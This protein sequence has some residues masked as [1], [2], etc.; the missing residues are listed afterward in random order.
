MI[1]CG[2]A[3]DRKRI[4]VAGVA[5]L[6]WDLA[7]RTEGVGPL[8]WRRME[9]VF[10]ALTCPVQASFRTE[11]M[12]CFHGMEGNGFFDRR[13]LRPF[14][15]EQSA[16]LIYGRRIWHGA[17]ERGGRVGMMFWQQSLGE[18]VDLV[19][20]PRPVHRHHGGMLMD[21]LSRPSPLYA[22][23]VRALG[24]PFP[25][26]RYWGPLAS[27]ESSAW[28]VDATIEV[29]RRGDGAPDLLLTY[30]P[31]LDYDLQR[32]GPESPRAARALREVRELL[33]RLVEAAGAC[34]YEVVMFGDYAMAP[35][36]RPP[37]W[38][39]RALREAGL[40]ATRRV[41]RHVYPDFFHSRAFAVADHEVGF[42]YAG[43]PADAAEAAACL[44]AAPGIGEVLDREGQRCAG[45]DD[46]DGADLVILA[47]EGAWIAYPWWTDPGEAPDYAP[48]VDIHNKPGYDPCEL[49]FG[50]PPPRTSLDARKVRGTHGRAGPGRPV[51]WATTLD[52]A[53]EPPHVM[54]LA[55]GVQDRLEALLCRDS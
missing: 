7:R 52:P 31:H 15:W 6:G 40:L 35:V 37:A 46:P 2:M 8:P 41:H 27:K 36:T 10:P 54:A 1:A 11:A 28:I 53:P 39:N 4:L 51:A 29:M 55:K 45:V 19:L 25:L 5:A 26:M 21:C 33:G 3:P 48:H 38:P 14:F 34:G 50:F 44:R 22:E 32:F 12:P 43:T 20:S 13:L 16:A 30:V 23:L 49:F 17:R 18:A 47:E 9:T 24:R 42:V